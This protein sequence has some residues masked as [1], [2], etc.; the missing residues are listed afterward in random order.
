MVMV[1]IKAGR[2]NHG[3][4]TKVVLSDRSQ[5]KT[6]FRNIGQFFALYEYAFGKIKLM[7]G[8]EQSEL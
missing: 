8:W 6:V 4:Y 2:I 3:E 1:M 5:R 7:S